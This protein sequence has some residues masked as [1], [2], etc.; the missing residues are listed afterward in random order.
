MIEPG[1]RFEAA[2]IEFNKL[3]GRLPR[4]GF[5]T[6]LPNKA[7]EVKRHPLFTRWHRKVRNAHIVSHRD[8]FRGCFAIATMTEA[9]G[10]SISS[11]GGSSL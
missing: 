5:G 1:D 6:L 2:A 8:S 3:G 4:S 11:G 10:E 9:A 7:Q